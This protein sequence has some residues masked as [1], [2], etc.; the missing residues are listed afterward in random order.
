[1]MAT[2]TKA[3]T[4]EQAVKILFPAGLLTTALT[5]VVKGPVKPTI[6]VVG[7]RVSV[8]LVVAFLSFFLA[9]IVWLVA[10]RSRSVDKQ[11]VMEDP[12]VSQ[13]T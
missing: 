12:G 9:V 7:I 3:A 2:S 8:F 13:S 10:I 11:R 6:T 5:A 1:M 4:L